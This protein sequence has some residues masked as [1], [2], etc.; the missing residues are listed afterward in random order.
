MFLPSLKHVLHRKCLQNI[1]PQYAVLLLHQ[2]NGFYSVRFAVLQCF[3]LS[4]W[5]D[6]L[7]LGNCVD[8]LKS[9]WFWASSSLH[10][11]FR[12]FCRWLPYWHAKQTFKFQPSGKWNLSYP[13]NDSTC[14]AT[15]FF[16]L[17]EGWHILP[18][19]CPETPHSPPECPSASS[20]NHV[21]NE[22]VTD[23]SFISTWLLVTFQFHVN[24]K[25]SKN[26]SRWWLMFL[27]PFL[28]HMF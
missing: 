14:G 1:H 10:S 9:K 7:A 18:D 12:A 4:L 22:C 27:L 15:F 2:H 26:A 23:L 5:L 28:A 24:P 3:F 8:V 17:W 19:H 25:L 21:S 13:S 11:P 16:S 20:F 6:S